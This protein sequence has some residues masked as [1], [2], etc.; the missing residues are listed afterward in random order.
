M[1]IKHIIAR[2]IGFA[3]GTVFVPTHGFSSSNIVVVSGP[4]DVT[5][6][7]TYIPGEQIGRAHV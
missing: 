6:A 2:G 3:G 4:W 7:Q 5:I 1:A